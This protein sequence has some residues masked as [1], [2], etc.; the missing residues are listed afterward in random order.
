MKSLY[1]LSYAVLATVAA[2]VITWAQYRSYK[3][4]GTPFNF[5]LVTVVTAVALAMWTGAALTAF[6]YNTNTV[7]AGLAAFTL[8][9][10][11]S[12]VFAWQTTRLMRNIICDKRA[13]DELATHDALTG[14]WNRR[15]FHES[16]S[17][18][19]ARAIRFKQPLSLLVMEIDNLPQINDAYGFKSGDMVLRELG[20]RLREVL[21][22]MDRA[23]RF[24]NNMF[25]LILPQTDGAAVKLL[26]A[27]L[28]S[29]VTEVPFDVGDK[30]SITLTFSMGIASMSE[31]VKEDASLI[32]AV[33]S[34]VDAAKASGGNCV[35][36]FAGE[37]DCRL[38]N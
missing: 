36:T 27:R 28:K 17:A 26:L 16:V 33:I 5:T 3:K 34:A 22:T 8:G 29:L 9:I 15:I 38:L 14:L 6:A 25:A 24:R 23:C 11:L 30:Q 37:G 20:A 7:T 10:S 31:H 21:R 2:I 18:E 12:A 32:S 4:E 13:L 35:Y 19:V 1:F